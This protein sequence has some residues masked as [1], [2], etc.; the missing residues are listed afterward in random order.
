[1]SENLDYLIWNKYL[2][3]TRKTHKKSLCNERFPNY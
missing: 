2:T 3:K 1:M